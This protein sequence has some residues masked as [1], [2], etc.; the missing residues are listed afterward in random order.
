MTRTRI[1]VSQIAILALTFVASCGFDP[2]IDT[3]G[4]TEEDL[5][6]AAAPYAE[7]DFAARPGYL[8]K[9]VV[10]L[11]F[12]DGPDWTNTARVLDVLRQKNAKAT[13]FINTRNWSNVD[14]EEPM[15]NLVRRMVNEGHELASHSVGHQHMA[16]L[17]TS[18]I[19]NE[20]AGVERT[21]RSIFGSRAP[22]LTLFRAPFGEPYQGNNPSNP[23]AGYRKVAPVVARHA[24]HI[25]WAVDSFDY[26]CAPGD[27]TCVYN[28]VKNVL[29]TPNTG[30][31]GIVLLHSVHAQ[32]AS[33]LPRIID[34]VRS[35]GFT[36]WTVE[37][38]VRRRYGRSSAQLV[39]EQRAALAPED[40]FYDVEDT[41]VSALDDLAE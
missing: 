3:E 33:A 32:T 8:P 24:V 35:K 23:R 19:E 16:S 36:L 14:T 7:I 30:A 37:Q 15:R 11:T 17:S 21:V 6:T 12:D 34:Y 22:R 4:D 13:F 39:D 41:E 26:N 18:A 2:E 10:V 28:N 25:G 9:N 27:G 5:V 1:Y 38:V 20:I 29:K 40:V 31:Y